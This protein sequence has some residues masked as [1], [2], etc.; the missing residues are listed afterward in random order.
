[1]LIE[2]EGSLKCFGRG[3]SFWTVVSASCLSASS[4]QYPSNICQEIR[5]SAILSLH[6]S[7][8]GPRSFW[9]R[10][11]I[12]SSRAISSALYRSKSPS[13]PLGPLAWSGG[14]GGA[15]S[16]SQCISASSGPGPPR[17]ENHHHSVPRGTVTDPPLCQIPHHPILD[18]PILCL[19]FSDL[20]Q[21]LRNHLRSFHPLLNP[22]VL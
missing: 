12:D 6:S 8:N 1:M 16:R 10:R 7:H 11:Q 17:Q 2:T 20:C 5:P 14:G 3:I 9:E 18:Q 4:L 15:G 21:I 19:P 13:D 22:S